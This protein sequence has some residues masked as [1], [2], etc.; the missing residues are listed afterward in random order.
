VLYTLNISTVPGLA[1]SL[2]K[3]K[4]P[5]IHYVYYSPKKGK[6][7]TFE[8]YTWDPKKGDVAIKWSQKTFTNYK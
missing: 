6:V 8:F 7:T 5:K 4:N 3:A 2:A 1:V